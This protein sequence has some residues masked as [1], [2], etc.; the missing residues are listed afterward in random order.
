MVQGLPV[1][2][3]IQCAPLR[4]PEYFL[5]PIFPVKDTDAAPNQ[6]SISDVNIG[7]DFPM[8]DYVS[9]LIRS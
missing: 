2:S 1:A 9:G 8:C 4:V 5:V 6:W 3:R 7:C